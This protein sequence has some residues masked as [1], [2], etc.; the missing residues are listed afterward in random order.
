MTTDDWQT[1]IRVLRGLGLE[2]V[3]FS[4]ASSEITVRVPE[5]RS[6]R[7]PTGGSD[8]VERHLGVGDPGG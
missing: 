4:P 5:V 8:A 2:I 6:D 1:L 7:D 3:G